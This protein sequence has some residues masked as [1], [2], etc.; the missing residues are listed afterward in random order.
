MLARPNRGKDPS[1]R[2]RDQGACCVQEVPFP[3]ESLTTL[4]PGQRPRVQQENKHTGLTHQISFPRGHGRGTPVAGSSAGPFGQPGW[5]S[6]LLPGLQTKDPA[7]AGLCARH[8]GQYWTKNRPSPCSHGSQSGRGDKGRW[9]GGVKRQAR[10]NF[11]AGPVV[12][13]PPCK[14]G[15]TGSSPGWGTKTPQALGQLNL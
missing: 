11:P 9:Q 3:Q 14:A 2:E 12:K 8:W 13:H 7:C 4:S 1:P 6:G 5:D 10:R 15:D